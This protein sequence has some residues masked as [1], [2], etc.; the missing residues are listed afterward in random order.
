MHYLGVHILA[1]RGLVRAVNDASFPCFNFMGRLARWFRHRREAVPKFLR[2]F[3]PDG[4]SALCSFVARDSGAPIA[5]DSTALVINGTILLLTQCYE[6][7][8]IKRTDISERLRGSS[9]QAWV[10][11]GLPAVGKEVGESQ[12]CFWTE[13]RSLT[14]SMCYFLRHVF[15]LGTAF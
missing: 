6:H 11:G 10:H 4:S 15:L 2:Q 8:Y 3:E 13:E 9:D 7:K 14:G 5:V 1:Y 12:Q